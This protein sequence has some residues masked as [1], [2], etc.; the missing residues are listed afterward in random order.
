MLIL[1]DRDLFML[2]EPENSHLD[3]FN[4][5]TFLKLEKFSRLFLLTKKAPIDLAGKAF[6]G[7]EFLKY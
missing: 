5:D 1:E 6:G 4:F 2:H 3:E 7:L